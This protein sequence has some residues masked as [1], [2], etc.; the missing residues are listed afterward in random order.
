MCVNG[1]MLIYLKVNHNYV[2]SIVL[3]IKVITS[4]ISTAS[5]LSL[6][7]LYY[8]TTIYLSVPWLWL[9]CIIRDAAEALQMNKYQTLIM[10]AFQDYPADVYIEYDWRFQQLAA[11]GKSVPW[12]KYKDIFV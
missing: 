4:L 10:A 8:K 12:D 1:W 3:S 6:S 5:R 7:Q 9:L 2:Q 11:K